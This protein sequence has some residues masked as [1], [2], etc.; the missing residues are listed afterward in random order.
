[1]TPLVGDD[2][3]LS[4]PHVSSISIGTGRCLSLGLLLVI[5]YERFCLFVSPFWLGLQA[6]LELSPVLLI[7]SL[8]IFI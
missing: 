8:H 7:I 4:L 6:V 5:V 1:M 2:F 3:L